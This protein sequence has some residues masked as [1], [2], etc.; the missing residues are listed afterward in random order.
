MFHLSLNGINGFSLILFI[1]VRITYH[2][3]NFN[4]HW[5]LKRTKEKEKWVPQGDYGQDFINRIGKAETVIPRI[6]ADWRE[7]QATSHFKSHF[8]GKFS[9]KIP[10]R[11]LQVINRGN[12]YNVYEKLNA[13]LRSEKERT[14]VP[15][16]NKRWVRVEWCLL[17]CSAIPHLII[18]QRHFHY[19]FP[20]RECGRCWANLVLSLLSTFVWGVGSLW[21]IVVKEWQAALPLGKT[22]EA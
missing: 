21:Y 15:Y 22:T 10:V 6:M 11:N 13:V 20:H 17:L 5:E 19:P 3:F 16:L 7:N 14:G 12:C 18:A 1:V 4:G 9:T 8:L 2:L